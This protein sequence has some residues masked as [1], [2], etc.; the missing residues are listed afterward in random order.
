MAA[1]SVR[2]A[3]QYQ[4]NG[5]LVVE[6]VDLDLPHEGE[7]RVKLLASAV[8]Q[9]DLGIAR[10]ERPH[11]RPL[12]LGHEGAGVVE[13]VGPGVTHLAPGDSVI[14]GLV[15][16]CGACRW[17]LN[18]RPVLCSGPIMRAGS[19]GLLPDGT[20]RVSRRGEPV[21]Q[22]RGVGTFAESV[23]VWGSQ[24]VPVANEA[25]LDK[26]CLLGCSVLTGVGAAV[27]TARVRAGS[28]CVVIGCGGVGLNV[29]QGC[30]I[31]GA[32]SI[33]AVDN[34]PQK[35]ELARD[36]GATDVICA[37][38]SQADAAGMIRRLTHGGADYAFEVIGRTKTMEQALTATARGGTCCI[39]GFAPADVKMQV[40][41]LDLLGGEKILTGSFYGS[42]RPLRDIPRLVDWYCQG[43]LRLDELISET[44]PLEGVNDAFQSLQEGT[45]ARSVLLYP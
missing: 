19:V 26:L 13:D 33:I 45:V 6:T 39:V 42:G 7:V 22:F 1:P 40:G 10:D 14:L 12:I 35:L 24:C 21:R 23:I 29:I 3:V 2:A 15:A 44:L 37:D 9:A 43:R 34:N 11:A 8:C 31:A 30:R 36:F 41:A 25:P 5:P 27:N 4:P 20:S 38:A 32:A 18:D 17:C 28:S 16:S